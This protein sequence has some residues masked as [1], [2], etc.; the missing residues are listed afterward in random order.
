M[1]LRP[2]AALARTAPRCARLYSTDRPLVTLSR[3]SDSPLAA[4][5][6]QAASPTP[7]APDA[8]AAAYEPELDSGISLLTL[9]RAPARNAI[10]MQLLAELE[11]CVE[12]ARGDG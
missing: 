1:L 2:L 11:E 8:R 7:G 3:L 4:A 6:R 5:S 9:D 12:A 10:S